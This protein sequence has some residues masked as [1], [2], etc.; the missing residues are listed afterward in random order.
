[1]SLVIDMICRDGIIV[2]SDSRTTASTRSVSDSES[3]V[4]KRFCDQHLPSKIYD[5]GYF[6]LASVGKKNIYTRIDDVTIS[7]DLFD[8]GDSLKDINRDPK[9]LPYDLVSILRRSGFRNRTKIILL[10]YC[11]DGI[12]D[13]YIFQSEENHPEGFNIILN[14]NFYQS[15][16]CC[17]ELSNT[18]LSKILST[19]YESISLEDYKSIKYLNLAE[20]VPIVKSV[21]ESCINIMDLSLESGIGF[22]IYLYTLNQNG[23]VEKHYGPYD[24]TDTYIEITAAHE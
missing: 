17:D 5:G 12:C 23:T 16:G 19:K 3:D 7:Y 20:C 9:N 21:L 15:Y 14:K 1:M 11:V 4:I 24:R 6:I 2:G 13:K 10:Y 18:I 22:P 8:I